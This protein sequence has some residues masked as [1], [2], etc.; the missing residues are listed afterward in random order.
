[1]GNKHIVLIYSKRA[2]DICLPVNL[3]DAPIVCPARDDS[4][5]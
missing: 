4:T 2:R 5:N 3:N 1:M